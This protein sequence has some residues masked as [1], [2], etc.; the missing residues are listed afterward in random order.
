MTKCKNIDKLLVP[1]KLS[2]KLDIPLSRVYDILN[3][4]RGF[5]L[6][7][8]GEKGYKWKGYDWKSEY[9]W[10]ENFEV[11]FTHQLSTSSESL[12]IF[13]QL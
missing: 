5:H 10:V 11:N 9:T 6:V 13:T 12:D 2:E 1:A 8:R 3:V 4:L 7:T